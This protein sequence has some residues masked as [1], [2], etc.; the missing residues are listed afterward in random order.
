MYIEEFRT[1]LDIDIFSTFEK[2]AKII[3]LVKRSLM[4]LEKYT[5]ADGIL[6]P[7]EEAKN[8]NYPIKCERKILFSKMRFKT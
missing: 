6:N 5:K 7:D 2:F 4:K 1:S 8:E 3:A